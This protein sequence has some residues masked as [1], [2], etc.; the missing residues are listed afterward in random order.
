MDRDCCDTRGFFKN[1]RGQPGGASYLAQ[2]GDGHGLGQAPAPAAAGVEH[3]RGCHQ[4][5]R[6]EDR[7]L[8]EGNAGPLAV[9]RPANSDR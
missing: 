7:G 9:N 4:R 1:Q 3:L 5:L 8:A 6:R 2:K